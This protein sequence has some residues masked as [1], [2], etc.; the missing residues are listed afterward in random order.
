MN[1]RFFSFALDQADGSINF[2]GDLTIEEALHIL[3]SALASQ[4]RQI[5][6]REKEEEVVE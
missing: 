5:E 2:A 6:S 4:V 1:T 3:I